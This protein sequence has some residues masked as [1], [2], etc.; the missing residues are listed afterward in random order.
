MVVDVFV[1]TLKVLDG[2]TDRKVQIIEGF[3]S[4][5]VIFIALCFLYLLY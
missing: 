3:A 2:I 5:E 1:S 4:V